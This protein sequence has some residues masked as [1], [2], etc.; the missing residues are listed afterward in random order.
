MAGT[1]RARHDAGM[2]ATTVARHPLPGEK[3][4]RPVTTAPD[5]KDLHL[6]ALSAQVDDPDAEEEAVAVRPFS[7]EWMSPGL[8]DRVAA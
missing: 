6:V 3:R 4:S 1:R 2:I 8:R 7:K 5:P